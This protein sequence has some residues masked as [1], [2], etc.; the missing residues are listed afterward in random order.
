MLY[1]PNKFID[2]L[3]KNKG[4]FINTFLGLMIVIIFSGG[5]LLLW[6]V[7]L[8]TPDLNSFDSR[9][10]GMSTKIYDRTGDVLLYDVNQ[11]VRRTVVPFNTISPYLKNAT[12]SIEDADFYKHPGI[13]ITSIF[14]AFIVDIFTLNF[15]QGG[16]TIT[17]QVVKNSLL[18]NQKTVSRKLKE[19][20]LAIKLE[21]TTDKDFILNLYL[22][23]TPY[24]GNI[25][26]VE[27]ASKAF[28][29]KTSSEVSIAQSAYIA[30]VAQAPTFYS[31][32]GANRKA[33]DDRKNLVL[34]K[35]FQY[36]YITQDQYNHAKKEVVTFTPQA[37]SAL[38]APHFVM[39]ILDYLQKKY[40][41]TAV[42]EGG[43]KITTTLDYTIQA[44]A[45]NMIKDYVLT[46]QSK[47]KAE[48]AAMVVIDP[49]T[50]QILTMVGSR[51]Y[52][53]KNIQGNF[54]VTT[55][56]RQPGS[57]FKPFIYVT[58]FNKGYTPETI[59][60]DVKTEFSTNCDIYGNPITPEAKC[61][62]P[63]NYEGGYKGPMTMR[64]A[65]GQSRN[66]PAVKALYLAGIEESLDTARA[67]G[68]QG[69][70][71][72]LST[73]GLSLALGSAEVSL[74]DMT[75]AYGTFANNGERN[76]YTGILKVE[77]KAGS[78]LEE[79]KAS[80]QQVYP[81]EPVLELNSVLSDPVARNSIVTL[82][83]IP[84]KKFAMKTGT[85]NDSR[86]AWILG[87]TPNLAVGAWMGNNNNSPMSQTSS[88]LIVGPLWQ[89]F[90]IETLKTIPDEDFKA[91]SYN[92]TSTET[93]S[94]KPVLRGVW[95]T[96][97]GVHNI[98]YYV[99]KEDPRGPAP[100]NPSSDPEFNLW[101]AGVKDWASKNGY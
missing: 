88:A 27:E 36:G 52:F 30:A 99:N 67:F 12:I 93:A 94:L 101:E 97:E 31:P 33:L 87:Y 16:S 19:W 82:N 4:L 14:R 3:T 40:G 98:L 68:I 90:M 79:F 81:E 76:P 72:D 26:G 64:S 77:D 15:T 13:Q 60:F 71:T 96:G 49:K 18:T 59:L 8:K 28:F 74:L 7:N 91:P 39:F 24:G 63:P 61:Y 38:K 6:A 23:Q 95:Q 9:L 84:G 32:F 66:V 34:Q 55:A 11:Q 43:L 5:G 10:A 58:D 54:N 20:I 89:K 100:T 62:H 2:Y 17:Q 41:E 70:S 45:E 57:S 46:N 35:M 37:T 50:G 29:G 48:N 75:S 78:T 73:Y 44:R 53:D 80:P 1:L 47:F 21:R 83:Y 65:L 92:A 56:H 86:D 85:T 69:L 51:D 42:N 25:Y 22:N